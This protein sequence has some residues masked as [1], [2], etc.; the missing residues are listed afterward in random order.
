MPLRF[1]VFLKEKLRKR[2]HTCKQKDLYKASIGYSTADMPPALG[3]TFQGS[4][5]DEL[6]AALKRRAESIALVRI[7]DES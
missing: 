3:G 5:E 4:Y 2:M 1:Q 7:P 6:R